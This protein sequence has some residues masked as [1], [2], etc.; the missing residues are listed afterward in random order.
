MIRS[1][2]CIV[3]RSLE[4]KIVQRSAGVNSPDGILYRRGDPANSLYF[5]GAGKVTVSLDIGTGAELRM[6]A[7]RGALLGL[8]AVLTSQ[9][10]QMTGE[11]SP[12]A[13]IYKL[14]SDTF[15]ELLNSEPGM[16]AEA[17]RI[18]ACELRTAR[19]AIADLLS[20]REV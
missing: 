16:Q 6:I 19:Q 1:F 8:A 12:D 17:L 10:H 7:D 3:D 2:A 14:S 11:A 18:L 5:V 15:E 13:Q 4:N 9:P 20:V